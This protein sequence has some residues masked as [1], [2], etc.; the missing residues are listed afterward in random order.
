MSESG[1]ENEAEEPGGT[2]AAVAIL[3]RGGGGGGIFPGSRVLVGVAGAPV[4]SAA[5]PRGTGTRCR[6]SVKGGET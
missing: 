6:S 1:L 3:Q 2:I 5:V 4:C